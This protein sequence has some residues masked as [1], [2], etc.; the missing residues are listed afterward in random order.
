MPDLLIPG[1]DQILTYKLEK[2]LQPLLI[3]HQVNHL[4]P[5]DA[6]GVGIKLENCSYVIEC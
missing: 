2:T 6:L 4:L 3:G 1:K 5:I